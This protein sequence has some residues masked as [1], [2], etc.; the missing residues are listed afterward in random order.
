LQ[1]LTVKKNVKILSEEPFVGFLRN[2]LNEQEC[3]E[4]IDEDRR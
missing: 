3:Q 2:F 4:L 1:D